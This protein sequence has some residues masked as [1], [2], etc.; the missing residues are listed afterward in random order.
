MRHRKHSAHYSA[1]GCLTNPETYMRLGSTD[2]VSR[3]SRFGIAILQQYETM[4][5]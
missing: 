3:S 4:A 1:P 2:A 5:V